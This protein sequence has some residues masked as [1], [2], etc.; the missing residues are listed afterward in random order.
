M[1][2]DELANYKEYIK[3]SK[4]EFWEFLVRLAHMKFHGETGSSPEE[5]VERALAMLFKPQS[6]QV[7]AA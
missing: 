6:V 7:Q 3:L 2:D 5:K 4:G 1:C